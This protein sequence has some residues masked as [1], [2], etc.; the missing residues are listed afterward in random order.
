VG[1]V[2]NKAGDY[3]TIF[4]WVAY[5]ALSPSGSVWRS[6][7]AHGCGVVRSRGDVSGRILYKRLGTCRD[8]MEV[9]LACLVSDWYCW[10]CWLR[11]R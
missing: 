7:E 2:K 6:L 8:G 9:D 10:V 11:V 3:L 4:R 1:W 5:L